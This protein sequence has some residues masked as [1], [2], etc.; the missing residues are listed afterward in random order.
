MKFMIDYGRFYDPLRNV[1]FGGGGQIFIPPIR[2]V[3]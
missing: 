2:I 1:A 3:L